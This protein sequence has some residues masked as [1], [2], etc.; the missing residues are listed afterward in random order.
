MTRR[1][2]IFAQN[3]NPP[4]RDHARVARCASEYRDPSDPERFF[5]DEIII[6]PSGARPDKPSINHV[7][8]L[9]RATMVDLAFRGIPRCRV[10]LFDLE[11][12]VHTP[13]IDFEER[14]GTQ[15]EVWQLVSDHYVKRDAGSSKM[16]AEWKRG[17]ELWTKGRFVVLVQEEPVSSTPYP[18]LCLFLKVRCEVPR[19]AEVRKA[20]YTYEEWFDRHWISPKVVE[21]I[22][23]RKLYQGPNLCN[24]YRSQL[25]RRRPL[26]VTDDDGDYRNPKTT[27]LRGELGLTSD[28]V[29][30]ESDPTCIIVL[31]GDGTMMRAIRKYWRLRVPFIGINA[32]HRGFHL[33]QPT[34]DNPRSLLE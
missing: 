17:E 7:T 4:N 16:E 15:G 14:Y 33:N 6:V 26:L 18:P 5:F 31:G 8:T 13:N 2:A 11:H 27:E 29:L 22:C 10:D 21:Y 1:I 24:P 9:D 28:E 12:D 32:G 19:S 20:I 30:T 3:F 25:D 23:L 34:A